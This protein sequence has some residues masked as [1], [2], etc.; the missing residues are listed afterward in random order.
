[1]K[2]QQNVENVENR[3][4]QSSH[5]A[6]QVQGRRKKQE[7]NRVA[8]NNS[9]KKNLPFNKDRKRFKLN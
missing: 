1:M 4:L 3:K 2:K 9:L 5:A 6:R 7:V 8:Q